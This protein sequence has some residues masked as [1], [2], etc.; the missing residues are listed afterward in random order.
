MCQ[1]HLEQGQVSN[2]MSVIASRIE[3]LFGM[4]PLRRRLRNATAN[5]TRAAIDETTKPTSMRRNTSSL[6]NQV[7]SR[8]PTTP[9]AHP[10]ATSAW[11]CSAITACAVASAS[12]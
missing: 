4:A 7:P 8:K 3:P 2:G 5:V 6:D 10:A 11:P 9:T 12:M 1:A